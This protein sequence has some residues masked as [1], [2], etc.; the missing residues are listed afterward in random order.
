MPPSI[1]ETYSLP[2]RVP[3]TA[4]LW[5]VPGIITVVVFGLWLALPR[6]PV[7]AG[8]LVV[9]V[10]LTVGSTIARILMSRQFSEM[11]QRKPVKPPS[12]GGD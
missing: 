6:T 9:V 7:V 4:R 8:L 11:P 12:T 2:K 5:I 1:R 3:V 10:I